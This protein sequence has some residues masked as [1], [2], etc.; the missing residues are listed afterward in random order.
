MAIMLA[1]P[2]RVK[3]ALISIAA[4]AVVYTVVELLRS[5]SSPSHG[6]HPY[7]FPGNLTYDKLNPFT[8][9]YSPQG[10]NPSR[11]PR[12]MERL[13]ER[14]RGGEEAVQQA[15]ASARSVR[16]PDQ[17]DDEQDDFDWLRGRTILL[18]G[19][20]LDRYHAV[21]MCQFLTPSSP[22]VPL[23]WPYEG[24]P[25]G[26]RTFVDIHP[27]SSPA[28]PPALRD[29]EIE[30]AAKYRDGHPFA[31]DTYRPWVCHIKEF[32]AAIVWV[33]IG[34]LDDGETTPGVQEYGRE[35]TE[36]VEGG[37]VGKEGTWGDREIGRAHV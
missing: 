27:L 9:Q 28:Y 17:T 21:H 12:L 37:L 31:T 30:L 32:D 16:P 5:T 23:A 11:A 15:L 25:D 2:R 24:T 10:G 33:F 14:T 20:S 22:L 34:G 36:V 3:T 35:Q 18:L 1:L 4:A 6:P 8:V 7:S 26:V 19:D 29:L 13:M